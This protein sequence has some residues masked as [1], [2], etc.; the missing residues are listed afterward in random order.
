VKHPTLKLI[1]AF[2]LLLVV[3]GS[4]S[5]READFL[6]RIKGVVDLASR[7]R[8][9]RFLARTFEELNFSWAYW[10]FSAG[11]DIYD[12]QPAAASSRWST[13]S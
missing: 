1:L 8:W 12:P 5:G 2:S 7:I 9:T 6:T 11:F 4:A 10:E 13:H 3:P